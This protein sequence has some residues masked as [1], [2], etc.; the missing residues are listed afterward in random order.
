MN[1]LAVSCHPDDIEIGCGGTLLRYAKEGHNV[2]ICHCA[3]GNLGHVAIAPDALRAE[4]GVVPQKALLFQGSIRSNL[5]WGNPGA[6]DDALWQ[7]LE[8]A[9]AAEMVRGKP[10]GLD[11]AV[12]QSGRNFSGGQRQRL[13][14]ARAL[15]RKPAILILDDSSSALDF[16]TDAALRRSLRQ[17]PWHPTVF[18][19]SQRV[20]SIRHADQIVVLEDGEVAGIGTHAQ[21]MERCGV[22]REIYRSQHKTEAEA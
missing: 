21:L 4:M 19:I 10:D 17:L 1:V 11:A 2:T 5:L 9:Q 8:A 18:L 12:E 16:A 22:Y 15:V 3:N 20:S 14:I 13:T 7:A 6:D